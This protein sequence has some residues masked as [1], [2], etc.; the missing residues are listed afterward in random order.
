MVDSSIVAALDL[1]K[2]TTAE[3]SLL[4]EETHIGAEEE[5][6]TRFIGLHFPSIFSQSPRLRGL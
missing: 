4:A 5:H 1:K 2:A 3:K 6:K